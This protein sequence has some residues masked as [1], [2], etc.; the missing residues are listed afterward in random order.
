MGTVAAYSTR[1]VLSYVFL[2]KNDIS[3]SINRIVL[4][5][6]LSGA[7]MGMMM[8]VLLDVNMIITLFV[9]SIAYVGA[10]VLT[11]AFT[12]EEICVVRRALRFRSGDLKAKPISV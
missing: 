5:P 4:K 12:R 1:F 8:Y 9:G 10:I 11:G 2:K 7:F 6:V 3:V